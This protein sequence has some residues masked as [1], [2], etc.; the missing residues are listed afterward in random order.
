M[1]NMRKEY[2]E[3]EK[4]WGERPE[5]NED[6]L[7]L[8]EER[9]RIT[10]SMIPRDVR[11]IIDAGCGDGRVTN[12]L[13]EFYNVVGFDSS[14][15]ALKHVK[16]E[17]IR[18]GSDYIPFKDNT[19]D[20]VLATELL[21]HLN[22]DIY[23]K[24]LKEFERI[25]RRYI[26]AS[27]PHK[28]KPYE[29][30]VKC[31][32]CGNIYSAYYHQRYFDEKKNSNLYRNANKNIKLI[33]VKLV[34]ERIQFSKLQRIGQVIFKSYSNIPNCVCPRCGSTELKWN[35]VDKIFYWRIYQKLLKKFGKKVPAW[36]IC[37]YEVQKMTL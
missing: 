23:K 8:E 17:K 1:I 30:Y 4:I 10:I 19:F 20:L 5:R 12:K 28:E 2:Y 14:K 33:N 7:T 13:L 26:L 36:M 22:D 32:D 29:T 9:V 37:L 35:I 34:G 27:V 16:C 25:S 18:G 31:K 6:A 15:T 21:E 3:Q 24:T 11:S